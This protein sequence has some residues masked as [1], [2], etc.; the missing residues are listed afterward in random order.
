MN[1][2]FRF[3]LPRE[4]PILRIDFGVNPRFPGAFARAEFPLSARGYFAAR[5]TLISL[6]AHDSRDEA[7]R[8]AIHCR[9]A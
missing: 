3:D 4:S 9:K 1:A 7:A 8:R 5:A 6:P 2:L